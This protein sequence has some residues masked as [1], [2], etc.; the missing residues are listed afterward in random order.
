MR[1]RNILLDKVCSEM[2]CIAMSSHYMLSMDKDLV[3]QHHLDS[4][5]L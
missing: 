5:H 4:M 2:D 3:R 1:C